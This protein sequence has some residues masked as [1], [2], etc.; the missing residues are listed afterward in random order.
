MSKPPPWSPFMPNC[1]LFTRE[2]HVGGTYKVQAY[3]TEGGKDGRW[4][5][6]NK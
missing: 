3:T 5:T 6:I 1:V 4:K 2:V